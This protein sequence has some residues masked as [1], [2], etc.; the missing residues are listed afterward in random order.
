M[1]DRGQAAVATVFVA[2]A[3]AG[4][5]LV[6]ALELGDRLLDRRTAQHAADAAALAGMTA[7][8][9]AAERVAAANGADLAVY[10]RLGDDVIVTVT[11]DS[12]AATARA[13][14]AP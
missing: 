7:G 10:E 5:T 1:R 2:T 12:M 11:V 3:L 14:R 13:S 9:R 4:A 6:G 8:R